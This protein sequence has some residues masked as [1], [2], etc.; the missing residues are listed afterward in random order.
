MS[1]AS[2]VATRSWESEEWKALAEHAAATK[3]LHLR[4]LLKDESR[5]AALFAEAEG[6][7]LD[8]SRQ[9]VTV[10]TME[11]LHALARAAR[12]PEKLDA[13]RGGEHINIT[14][15]R[16]VMHTALRA[17]ADEVRIV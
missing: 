9:R 1:V 4:D 8:Y 7:S 14:E 5:S 15:D 6:I 12:L 11:L 17:Q 16:A 2:L 10:E 13:M 3:S